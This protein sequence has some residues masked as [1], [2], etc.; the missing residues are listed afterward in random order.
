MKS[1]LAERG[2]VR[3]SMDDMT[4]SHSNLVK[5]V[6]I[7][8]N[9]SLIGLGSIY[10]LWAVREH[11]SQHIDALFP[12][13]FAGGVYGFLHWWQLWPKISRQDRR[14]ERN[15]VLATYLNV[16]DAVIATV[17]YNHYLAIPLAI[18]LIIALVLGYFSSHWWTVLAASFGLGGTVALGGCILRKERGIGPIY[19]Q[20][21]NTNWQGAEGM[22]YKVGKVE[23]RLAPKGMIHANG[24]LWSA[25][26]LSGEAIEVGEQV[27]VLQLDGLKLFVDRVPEEAPSP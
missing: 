5:Q 17:A 11:L 26:S 21:D 1:R 23:K 27:E 6:R 22:L 12:G 14:F 10:I 16:A 25:V 20:Y 19:Y 9:V 4:S 24:E 2:I 7:I 18:A 13:L 3:H 15:K 8:R